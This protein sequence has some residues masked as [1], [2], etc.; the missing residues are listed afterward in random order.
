MHTILGGRTKGGG[1][2]PFVGGAEKARRDC[3]K[4]GGGDVQDAEDRTD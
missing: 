3:L 2:A 1:W 4:Y